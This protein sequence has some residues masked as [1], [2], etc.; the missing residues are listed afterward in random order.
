[1]FDGQIEVGAPSIMSQKLPRE[2]RPILDLREREYA[3]D[4]DLAERRAP[5]VAVSYLKYFCRYT[6]ST[7]GTRD[8]LE[9]LSLIDGCSRPVFAL[10]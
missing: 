4:V 1:M 5:L 8:G 10:D 7:R 6:Q 9:P 2:K 3:D